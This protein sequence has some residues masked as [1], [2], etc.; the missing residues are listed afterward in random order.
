MRAR[1]AR[2]G[3]AT[4]SSLSATEEFII[5][6]ARAG[7]GVTKSLTHGPSHRGDQIFRWVVRAAGLVILVLL[8][9]IAVFLFVEAIPALTSDKANFFT[10]K[11]WDPDQSQVFGI[12]ALA[13][14]SVVSSIIALVIGV[15]I[16]VAVA[17][18][19]AQYASKA[20]AR[21]LGYVIDL[22]AAVPSVVFGL[23][24]LLWL[25]PDLI[26]VGQFLNTYLGWIPI[27]ASTNQTYGKSMFAAGVVL[28]VMILPIVAAISREV[29][30]Q[31]PTEHIEAAYALGATRWE[32]VRM[33]VLPHGRSG[34]IS[35]IVLGF[36]RAVGETIA[37]A[38]V[39]SASNVI[40][41]HILDPA[42]A[43][44]AANIANKFGDAGGIGRSALIASGLVLFAITLIV[45]F[46]ARAV[47]RRSSREKKA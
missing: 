39:L 22:L 11:A 35:A 27:F 19:I 15:P 44:I 41:I 16:A 47:V 23:W 29:F 13:F 43:T 32:M 21:P 14:G 31:T 36:G 3:P 37:I 18:Y 6:T 46:G 5:T 2:H 24:G 42:G 40:S 10:T 38:L 17:L 34:V 25:V 28:A 26:P 45:N 7:A 8:A 9:A 1:R 4:D 33:A 12:A 30:V 20:I